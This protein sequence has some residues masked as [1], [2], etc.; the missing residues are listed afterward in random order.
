MG[1]NSSAEPSIGDRLR[2]LRR[3]AS[4]SL[5]AC[6]RRTGI[7]KAMLGQIERGESSPTIA[8]LWKIATGLDVSLS[9]FLSI[10]TE[11]GADRLHH[12]AADGWHADSAGMRTQTLLPYDPALGFEM[13]AVEFAPGST[14]TSSPHAA[15]T[16]E[17]VVLLGGELTVEV[18]GQVHE[19]AE[20][21]VL[22][23]AADRAHRYH[24]PGSQP[25]RV[26]DL[27]HYSR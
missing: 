3:G 13:F 17:H 7:S 14:S 9:Y 19:L 16:I 24:N 10:A 20:G 1:A 21:D 4:L 12:P 2:K 18:G 23:F 11:D 22:Q 8:T 26:H 27:I 25:A 15:G 5:D 6:A